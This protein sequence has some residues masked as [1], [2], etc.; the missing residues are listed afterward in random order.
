MPTQ[1]IGLTL[2]LQ[3]VWLD[4]YNNPF[5][6]DYLGE[7]EAKIRIDAFYNALANYRKKIRLHRVNPL[8]KEEWGRIER[9]KLVRLSK[10]SFILKRKNVIQF[11]QKCKAD[12]KKLPYNK[13][14]LP[15]SRI[16]NA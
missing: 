13:F 5:T 8:Y 7:P 11:E 4:A 1:E 2:Y 14:N 16:T 10:T 3:K 6:V 15:I 9:C 12:N